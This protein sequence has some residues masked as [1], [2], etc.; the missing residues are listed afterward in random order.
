M[1]SPQKFGSKKEPGKVGF[2]ACKFTRHSASFF[3]AAKLHE[4]SGDLSA[5]DSFARQSRSPAEGLQCHEWMDN[6]QEI[7]RPIFRGKFGDTMI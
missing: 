2:P 6:W 3:R 5:S 4:N 1:R 7:Y